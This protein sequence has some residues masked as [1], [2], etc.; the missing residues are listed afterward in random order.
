MTG[1][2]A[3]IGAVRSTPMTPAS[4]PHWKIATTTPKDAPMLSRFMATALSGTSTERNTAMRSNADSATTM[5]MNSGSLLF[6]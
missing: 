5:P 3:W 2:K 4:Q 1:R 6:R